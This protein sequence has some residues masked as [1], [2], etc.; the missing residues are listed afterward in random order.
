MG[1]QMASPPFFVISEATKP[2][3]R[4]LMSRCAFEKPSSEDRW[5]RTMSPSSSVT[6]RPPISSSLTSTTLARVDFPALGSPVK[7]TV[8]PCW[9]RGGWVRR[10]SAITSGNENQGGTSRPSLS[11]ARSSVPERLWMRAPA[12]TSSS[13]T[14]WSRSSR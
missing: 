3:R 8:N 7:K 11:R 14:Y 13:G 10:N 2:I 1:A 6:G 4:M 5:V 12:G 9:L